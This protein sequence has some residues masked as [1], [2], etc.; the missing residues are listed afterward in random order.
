MTAAA[1]E[2]VEAVDGNDH[3]SAAKRRDVALA[4]TWTPVPPVRIAAVAGSKLAHTMKR[5][6]E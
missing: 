2:R 1:S 5:A 6:A 4:S 3:A